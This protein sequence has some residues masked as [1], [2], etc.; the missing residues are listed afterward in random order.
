MGWYYNWH[1]NR[2]QTIDNELTATRTWT[3]DRGALIEASTVKKCYRGA[4]WKGTLWAVHEWKNWKTGETERF[5]GCYLMHYSGG[6]W[7][8]KPL[9]ESMGPSMVNCPI[10]YLRMV[11]VPDS[12]WA[13]E[14]RRD[15]AA[16]HWRKKKLKEERKA[17][18][19]ECKAWV[20]D[21]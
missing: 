15:V 8:Y 19:K 1:W 7:G 3:R 11:P 13:R 20:L 4:A 5:I 16:Y 18:L 2:Q 6:M 10:S 14:W 12:K 17:K 21:I 9:E